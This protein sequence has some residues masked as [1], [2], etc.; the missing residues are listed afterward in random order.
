MIGEGAIG[1]I[2]SLILPIRLNLNCYKTGFQWGV[3]IPV[4]DLWRDT[5]RMKRMLLVI[6]PRLP[7][8]DAFDPYRRG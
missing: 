7:N 5:R 3:I 6:W 4:S 1:Y 2:R 8:R